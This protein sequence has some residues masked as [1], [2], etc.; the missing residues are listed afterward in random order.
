MEENSKSYYVVPS[1][2]VMEVRTE[3]FVCASGGTESYNRKD[4]QDW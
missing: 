1:T 4:E 2:T 3:G